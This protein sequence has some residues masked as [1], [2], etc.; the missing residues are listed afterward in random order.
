MM[1]I[2]EQ[3]MSKKKD[4]D[5]HFSNLSLRVLLPSVLKCKLSLAT[6]NVKNIKKKDKGG[7]CRI[8]YG[9]LK[10]GL[11][12]GDLK[13]VMEFYR[14]LGNKERYATLKLS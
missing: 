11:R 13:F 6:K 9:T 4:K 7:Q 1:T 12:T 2:G 14:T 3:K 8:I 5:G 10:N